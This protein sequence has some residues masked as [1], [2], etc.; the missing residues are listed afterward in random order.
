MSITKH[1]FVFVH[2]A[3]HNHA[4]WSEILPRLKSAGFAA[5]ALDLPGAEPGA[6]NPAC[7]SADPLD[8]AVFATEPS[9]SAAITQAERNA[10]VIRII[11]QVA[12][13]CDG[14]VVLIGHSLGGITISPIA[15]AI[16]DKIASLVY[17]TAFMLPPGVNAA[18]MLGDA[19]M[20]GES[21]TGLLRADPSVVGA[22]RMDAAA[23]DPAYREQVTAAFFGDLTPNQL[24]AA[25]ANLHCDEPAGVALEPSPVTVGRFGTVP[26]H[27][28]RCTQDRVIVLAAQDHM[29]AQ[30]DTVMPTRTVTH[31]L[32]SSHSAFFSQPDA[33]TRILIE[34]GSS[35][36]TTS[37]IATGST[38]P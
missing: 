21:I 11:E 24:A 12:S 16:P 4:A 28:I 17:L 37:A 32:A 8:P 3:W 25:L 36:S 29:I 5:A 27:Y 9:P 33:L 15:E 26:R 1:G 10:A 20:A 14:K 38:R 23:R 7:F 35:R 19:S 13:Q 31:T 30:I 22:F 2:G 18:T 34:I 6:G